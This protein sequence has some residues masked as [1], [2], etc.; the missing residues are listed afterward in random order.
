MTGRV[1]VTGA[2][3]FI[4][5]PLVKA[6]VEDGWTVIGASRTRPEQDPGVADWIEVDLLTEDPRALAAAARAEV[7]V[8]LAWI[9]TP[10]VYAHSL[11]NLDWLRA[12]TAL[13]AAFLAEGG[14]RLVGAGTCLEYDLDRDGAETTGPRT[15]YA[16][17]KHA[18]RLAFERQV[19][20]A[21]GA[22]LAWPRIFF[23]LGAEDHPDRFAPSL[24]RRL[25][26]RE[27]A[28][29]SQGLVERDFID[30]RDAA[31]AIAALAGAEVSGAFDIASGHGW[32][33]RDL[34][35]AIAK[36]AGRPDLL[37]INPALDRA[38]EPPRLVGDPRPLTLATGHSP[39][40]SIDQSIA[41]LLRRGATRSLNAR[42]D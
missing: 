34:A 19:A 8:H 3:G 10:G 17:A 35:E 4:G 18:C 33:L 20:E 28:E 39:L 26:A 15:L 16:A 42:Y 22:S 2:S 14:R 7:L 30:V 24:A 1:L 36:A 40:Y 5:R 32:R 11:E 23:L 29:I 25:M 41:D 27:P 21:P 13:S 12:S 31:R 6:L 37:Q 38:G 9:A